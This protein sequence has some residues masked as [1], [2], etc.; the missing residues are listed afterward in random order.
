MLI[1]N[2]TNDNTDT[3]NYY[4]FN[5][6]AV[7][8]SDYFKELLLKLSLNFKMKLSIMLLSRIV[9]LIFRTNDLNYHKGQGIGT[10]NSMMKHL[11]KLTIC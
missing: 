7:S 10:Y 5:L 3:I 2:N 6:N 11:P 4:F 1:F 9:V 8:L